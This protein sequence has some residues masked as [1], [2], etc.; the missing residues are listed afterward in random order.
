MRNYR[1]VVLGICAAVMALAGTAC[2]TEPSFA[3]G[4]CVRI[5]SG[6]FSDDMKKTDCA[7]ASGTFDPTERVYRVNE[8]IEGTGGG[9][10][11]L[12]GFFPVEFI[13]EPDDATYCLVQES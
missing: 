10:P 2:S 7:G 6:A 1:G 4:D 12:Q 3:V 11:Q 5:E 8:V 9:C 13:H